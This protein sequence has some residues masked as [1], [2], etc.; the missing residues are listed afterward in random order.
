MSI[1]KDFKKEKPPRPKDNLDLRFYLCCTESGMRTVLSWSDGWNCYTDFS[2]EVHRDN[3]I[4]D[5]VA[6]MELPEPFMKGEED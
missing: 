1:W 6:W 3:E 2:G 4:K 5:I